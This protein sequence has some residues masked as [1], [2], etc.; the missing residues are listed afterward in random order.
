[1]K[2]FKPYFFLINFLLIAC[3]SYAQKDTIAPKHAQ[4]K[5]LAIKYS[6]FSLFGDY[7]TPSTGI[8]LGVEYQ[9]GK[10][11]SV[12]QDVD[13]IFNN[14]RINFDL[15]QEKHIANKNDIIFNYNKIS[16]F[17][18]DTEIKYFFNNNK[19]NISGFYNSFHFMYQ[20]T[21]AKTNILYYKLYEYNVYENVIGFHDKIGYQFLIG[22]TKGLLIDMALGF[23]GRYFSTRTNELETFSFE[24]GHSFF[25]RYPHYYG[26]YSNQA[27]TINTF[28]SVSG[29]LKIGFYTSTK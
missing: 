14:K 13:Y 6:P 5:M 16:G 26:N 8:Q 11:W 21:N 28:L 19:N 18:F 27:A 7:M 17:R 24:V 4:Q 29:S 15:F 3:S 1:M 25:Y 12:E 23:G 20:Y 10:R 22:K 9:I 2:H